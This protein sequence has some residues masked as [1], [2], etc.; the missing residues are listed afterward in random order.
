MGVLTSLC[1]LLSLLL[2]VSV[3]IEGK[4]VLSSS[5]DYEYDDLSIPNAD[6]NTVK[7]NLS[8]VQASY[9]C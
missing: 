8:L 5:L 2:V 7:K 6:N 4:S 9:H 3:A 1:S